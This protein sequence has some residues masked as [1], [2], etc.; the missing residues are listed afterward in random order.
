MR[1]AHD[2]LAESDL[3][4]LSE[5]FM[6]DEGPAAHIPVL[7]NQIEVAQR[8]WD[9]VYAS[10]FLYEVV[11]DDAIEVV[12]R[13][14]GVEGR[15]AHLESPDQL[16]LWEAL[17]DGLSP[18]QLKQVASDGRFNLLWAQHEIAVLEDAE[19]IYRDGNCVITLPTRF[20]THAPFKVG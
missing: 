17:R 13:L 19:L 15:V 16:F 11:A 7:S 12:R 2:G 9:D 3:F 18:N 1:L 6:P 10:T 5:V 4:A 8:Q 14:D 20:E